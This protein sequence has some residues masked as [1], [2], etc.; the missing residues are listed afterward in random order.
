M[1]ILYTVSLNGNAKLVQNHN[2]DIDIGYIQGTEHFHQH[3]FPHVS[4][5]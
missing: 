1:C 2:Q 4:L 5:L 3:N